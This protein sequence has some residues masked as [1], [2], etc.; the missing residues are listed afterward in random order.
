MFQIDVS[1]LQCI[2]Y[3]YSQAVLLSVSET[4]NEYDFLFIL[5]RKLCIKGP[6]PME[7]KTPVF[8]RINMLYKSLI[9]FYLQSILSV[10]LEVNLQSILSVALEVNSHQSHQTSDSQYSLKL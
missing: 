9:C 7:T 2:E 5:M 4:E 6:I 10:A 1:I 8:V 3:L